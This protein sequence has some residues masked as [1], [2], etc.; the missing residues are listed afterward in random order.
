MCAFWR[1]WD[2]VGDVREVDKYLRGLPRKW[3][4]QDCDGDYKTKSVGERSIDLDA[5]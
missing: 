4:V 2:D 3:K 1:K 5:S